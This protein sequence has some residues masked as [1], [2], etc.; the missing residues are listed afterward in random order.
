MCKNRNNCNRCNRCVKPCRN[1]CESDDK[2]CNPP[3][4]EQ[5]DKWV[6]ADY[7]INSEFKPT[8]D[9]VGKRY[10]YNSEMALN[11]DIYKVPT[12]PQPDDYPH[13]IL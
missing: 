12:Q 1:K 13:N 7:N 5:L 11:G 8:T 3:N 6:T 2:S 4:V 9:F 10:V